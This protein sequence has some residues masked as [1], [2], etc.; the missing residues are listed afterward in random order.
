MWKTPSFYFFPQSFLSTTFLPLSPHC[1]NSNQVH[2][3]GTASAHQRFTVPCQNPACFHLSQKSILKKFLNRF[4]FCCHIPQMTELFL[5]HP[6]PTAEE[7]LHKCCNQDLG[8][9]C[10]WNV[11]ALA[12]ALEPHGSH[13]QIILLPYTTHP[14]WLEKDSALSGR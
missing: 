3:P 8:K 9:Q 1:S 6:A 2:N 10:N 5:L 4:C 7:K 13:N 14:K 12:L 11:T